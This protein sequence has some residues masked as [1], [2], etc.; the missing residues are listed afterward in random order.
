MGAIR[1]PEKVKPVVGILT[2][3]EALVPKVKKG[4]EKI[5]GEADYESPSIDFTH[6]GYYEEEMGKGLRRTFFT[7]VRALDAENIYSC[8]IETDRLEKVFLDEKNGRRVNIDPGYLN[9]SKLVLL[10]T[11]DYSHRIYLNGGIFAEVTLHYKDKSFRP[12][13]WTYPDYATS[14]YIKT[15]NAIRER[16]KDELLKIG[17]PR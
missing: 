3:D 11:K 14:E 9:L 12:W 16:Y 10:S 1:A 17:K 2:R 7:F 6:T 13:P 5:F 8:K 4:L 15:F